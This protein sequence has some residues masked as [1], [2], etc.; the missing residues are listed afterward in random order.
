MVDLLWA[1]IYIDAV[2][3]KYGDAIK[4]MATNEQERIKFTKEKEESHQKHK[5]TFK[6][7]VFLHIL[8]G[9]VLVFL[10]IQRREH[11]NAYLYA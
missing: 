3:D 1:H 4:V 6:I 10:M 9:C 2:D 7:Y 11:Y 5:K 8:V